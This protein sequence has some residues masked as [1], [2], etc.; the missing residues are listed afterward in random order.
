MKFLPILAIILVVHY[1]DARTLSCSSSSSSAASKYYCT[2]ADNTSTS[3]CAQCAAGVKYWCP[4]NPLLSTRSWIKGIKV[5]D[6]CSSIPRYTAIATF[7]NGAYSGHAAVFISCS[8]TSIQVYDQWDGKTWG[9]RTI[10]N[11]AGSISNNPN[12]FYTVIV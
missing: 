5:L 4:T 9:P 10:S 12:Y 8:G 6:N 7:P 11:T 2:A 3:A 1:S